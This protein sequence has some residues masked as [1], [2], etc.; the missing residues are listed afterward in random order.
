MQFGQL[1]RRDFLMLLGS[2]AAWPLAAGAQQTARPTVGVLGSSSG[3]AD[4]IR[5]NVEHLRR[6]LSDAGFV[7]GQ[8]L[9]VEYRW[10]EGRYERLPALAIE[11]VRHPVAVLVAAGITAAVAAKAATSTIP[12]V[13]YTGG[14]PVKLGLVGSL[15]KPDGNATGAVYLGKQLV[16]K[17]FELL[18]D[19]MPKADAIAF[20]VNPKNAATEDETNEMQAAAS[21]LGQKLLVVRAGSEDDLARAFATV[22]RERAGA[23]I[24]QGD[25]VLN[26]RLGRL[27]VLSARHGIPT[28]SPLREYPAAG[29]LMSYGASITETV[30]LAGVYCG[31]ILKGERPADLPVQ[32][33][34][35]VELVINLGT[36]KTLGL[37]VPAS[38]LARADEVIE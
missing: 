4:N 21:A 15:N 29:G 19:L 27:A 17:Q 6:G 11:L 26:S 1:K 36:A 38:V 32:Q 20:L 12:I 14:D 28:M 24:L 16:A 9:V 37:D 13:F 33:G 22:V 23:L 31:R 10:A 5:T 2:A 8:N 3:G 34:T 30:R 25:P 7:E 35:K 18:H